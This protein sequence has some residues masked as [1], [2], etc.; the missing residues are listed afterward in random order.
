MKDNHPTGSTSSQASK[1][2]LLKRLCVYVK[3]LWPLFLGA[4]I[5]NMVFAGV[6]SY[7]TYL[8][9]PLL[10]KGFI[11]KDH[12]FLTFFPFVIIALFLARGL[13]SFFGTY[14]LGRIGA[15]LVLQLRT[16]LFDKFIEVPS[17]FFD[18]HNPGKLLSKF[19][20]NVDQVAY[21]TGQSFSIL[22]QQSFFVIGL[23]IVMLSVSWKLSLIVFVVI[24]LVAIL[25]RYVSRRFRMLAS[26]IQE[27]MG[28][29]NHI[30]EESIAGQ[31]EI[32]IFGAQAYQRKL[33][34]YFAQYNFRQSIKMTI[35]GA[36]NTPVIQFLASLSLALIVFMTFHHTISLSA[37]SFIT[38]V[39]AMMAILRPLKQ[40]SQVNVD[41]ARG[42]AAIESLFELMDEPEE[43]D[44]GMDRLSS[45]K[46]EIRFDHVSFS[47]GSSAADKMILN[48]ISLIIPAGKT[49]AFVGK[50]GGGK[51]TLMSLLARF[52]VPSTGQVLI[53]GVDI[54]T[55]T[56]KNLREQLALVSQHVTLFDDTVFRNISFGLEESV[57]TEEKVIEAAKAANAWDFIQGLPL[58]LQT[59]IGQNGMGLS[60]GQRQRLAIARAILKDAPILILDEA[61]SALDNESEQLIQSSLERLKKNRTTLVI[62]HRLSTIEKADRIVVISEGK[63]LEEGTHAELMKNKGEYFQLQREKNS[64]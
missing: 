42:L 18:R 53:D 57:V 52:Y 19:T 60:G 3:P 2:S 43:E 12:T 33:F 64:L 29:L 37:G 48:D 40:L 14:A 9:K 41:I 27:T 22:I 11:A 17:A 7:A 4:I 25:V 50:S 24:P 56:L 36:A 5:A 1:R 13:A 15:R 10:D 16:D 31:K 35:T 20:F 63:I 44:R 58:G 21:T 23:L 59:K 39:A 61:T 32:K 49:I 34:S 30:V 46:G 55:L 54:Q 51:T 8:F 62:A 26:R 38:F 47:Y 28:D 45:V 6:D